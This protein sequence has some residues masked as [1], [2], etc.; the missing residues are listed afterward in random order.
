MI[1]FNSDYLEGAHPLI[2]EKLAA[3]NLEQTPGYGE[4]EYCRRAAAL[5][6]RECRRED[7]DVHFL[8]GGT[9]T[10]LTVIASALRPHQGVFAA[11]TGHINVHETGAIEATGHKVITLPETDGKLQAEAVA[12]YMK[13]YWQDESFEHVVQPKMVYLSLPTELGSL[14]SRPE[15]QEIAAVCRQYQLYLYID[16]ARLGY[17]LAAPDCDFDLPFLSGCADAFYIGGTKVGAL[18]GEALIIANPALKGDFRYLMKQ[19]GGLLA[20]GRLLGIQFET[21]FTDGLYYRL[22]EHAMQMAARLKQ[23]LAAAGLAFYTPPVTNQLFVRLPDQVYEKLKAEF[24]F[25]TWR[26]EG[27]ETVVR[28]CTSWATPVENIDVLLARLQ[29]LQR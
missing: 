8:V 1:Q 7:I 28:F 12:A 4:D 29:E 16:G 21:L 9:Q 13:E 3:T 17:G 26:H 25:E 20:K 11:D 27:A 23:G 19:K 5:I 18:F 14:Y 24:G 2:I 22:G 10:N 6:K 15:L